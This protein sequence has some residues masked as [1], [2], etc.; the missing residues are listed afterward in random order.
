MIGKQLKEERHERHASARRNWQSRT[1][2]HRRPDPT[3]LHVMW[4]MCVQYNKQKGKPIPE[5]SMW[6]PVHQGA[7]RDARPQMADKAAY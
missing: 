3:A 5:C 7:V 2:S 6:T 4:M 1:E